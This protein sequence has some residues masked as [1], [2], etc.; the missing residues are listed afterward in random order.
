MKGFHDRLGLRHPT[1]DEILEATGVGRSRAYEVA[2]MI[3]GVLAGLVRPPGRPP[4]PQI[5]RAHV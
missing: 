4:A 2:A 5:G 3:P 1:L